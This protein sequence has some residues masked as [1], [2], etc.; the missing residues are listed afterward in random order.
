VLEALKLLAEAW[1]RITTCVF[2]EDPQSYTDQ[3]RRFA[4]TGRSLAGDLWLQLW[5]QR[6]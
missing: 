4:G 1:R 3:A 5:L 6:L 2:D